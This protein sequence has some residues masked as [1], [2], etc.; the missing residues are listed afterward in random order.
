MLLRALLLC[1]MGGALMAATGCA[2]S[3]ISI[4]LPPEVYGWTPEGPDERYDAATLYDYIDGGAEVYRGFN[5]RQVLARRYVK[6]G[7]PEIITDVFDMG[8]SEDAFG[9]YHHDMREGQDVGIGQESEY[10]EGCLSFWKDRYFVSI[11]AFDETEASQRAVLELGKTIAEAIPKEGP[12]PG[13]IE[14]LPRNRLLTKHVHYFHTHSC[15]NRHYFLAE[16]N[17]LNL[18]NKT[19]GVLA[20]CR[21]VAAAD[22]GTDDS[23]YVLLLIRYRSKAAARTAHAR[24]LSG[25]LPDADA[26]GMVQTENGKWAGGVLEGDIFIGVFDAPSKTELQRV[27]RDV[28]RKLRGERP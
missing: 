26:Q 10:M 1:A 6:K 11:I 2:H 23:P 5:V 16:D 13:V 22:S 3:S 27:M 12:P 28:T 25:Y 19:Q 17:I 8:S 21:P 9:A 7:A 14:F 15:L 24:F 18:D 4:G 20:Q